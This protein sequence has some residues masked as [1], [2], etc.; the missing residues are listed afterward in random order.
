MRVL[1]VNPRI[2]LPQLLGGVETTTYD[3][4][5]QL[6][7][8]GHTAAVMCQVGR[9]DAIWLHNRIKSRL[10]RRA[11]P[12]TSYRGL[13]VYRGYSHRTAIRPVVEDFGPDAI[14]ISGG[15]D[16]SFELAPFCAATGVR[17]AFYFH[18]LGSLRRLRSPRLLDGLSLIANSAY[19][20]GVV[21][22][23]IGLDAAVIPPL[24]DRDAYALE[25]TRACVTM[26]NPRRIKGGQIAFDLAQACPDIPFMFVEAWNTED[27]FVRGLCAAAHELPNVTWREPTLNMRGI[28]AHT[29]ILLVPSQWEETW[30]RVVTEAHASGIPVLAR[31][32]AGLPESVGG[33]GVLIDPDAPIETWIKALRSMWDDRAHYEQ[34]VLRTREFSARP[35]AQPA[36]LAQKLISSLLAPA[37]PRPSMGS[38]P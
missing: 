7:A 36:Y 6:T 35:E 24:T 11:F 27:T 31:A 1:F 4:C 17:S 38:H 30:G 5:R 18:E 2:Y 23:L 14:I 10:T 25:T 19:T 16:E 9:H 32:Y 20:A 12:R 29:R 28:Y 34:L 22:Q 26:V 3:L 15:A 13:P 37:P 33:G 8:M 21:K